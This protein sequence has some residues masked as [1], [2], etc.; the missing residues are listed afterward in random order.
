MSLPRWLGQSLVGSFTLSMRLRCNHT[1]E[2]PPRRFALLDSSLG[3]HRQTP[4]PLT[5]SLAH[6]GLSLTFLSTARNDCLVWHKTEIHRGLARTMRNETF[7]NARCISCHWEPALF[8]AGRQI[9]ANRRSL[10]AYSEQRPPG[11]QN[12]RSSSVALLAAS[13]IRLFPF[14]LLASLTS[15]LLH[16]QPVQQ[17]PPPRHCRF[18][19][20]G[21]VNS[22]TRENWRT[23]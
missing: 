15:A 12:L 2:S 7:N 14:L 9:S 21:N 20:Q 5:F 18:H 6:K 10:A 3:K 19:Q 23:G 8:R 17:E 16:W 13:A 22:S 1:S 11:K 4:Y